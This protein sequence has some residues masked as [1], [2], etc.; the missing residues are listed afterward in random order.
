[1]Q[2][3]GPSARY[4]ALLLAL[5]IFAVLVLG[6]VSVAAQE[7]AYAAP[8]DLEQLTQQAQ[9]ILRGHVISI[10]A[11]PH[12]QFS[13]LRTVV[14]TFKTD[15]L[16]KG[17]AEPTFTFRQYVWGAGGALK[18]LG[19]GKAEELLLFL[20]PVS[21]YGLTS[22]V[23]L[24]QGRFRIERDTQG[25]AYAL[26]GRGNAG[27]FTQVATKARARGITLSARA[28]AMMSAPAAGK[29]SLEVLEETVVALAE[30][31]R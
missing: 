30:G 10:R 18:E 7:T 5:L 23:G 22:P 27:L 26:N 6:S 28:V 9:T 3:I 21:Q 15:R 20:N 16:L 29:V 8:A 25:N 14:V 11:E 24:D 12:P 19:Y 13:S 1:M 2:G 17:R 4:S 31:Q